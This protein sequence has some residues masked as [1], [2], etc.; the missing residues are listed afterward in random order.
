M[1]CEKRGRFGTLN[2]SCVRPV[3]SPVSVALRPKRYCDT[4]EAAK[5][6][7]APAGAVATREVHGVPARRQRRVVD[8]KREDLLG[9]G[10]QL[11]FRIAPH[12]VEAPLRV[13]L[14]RVVRD[15]EADRVV[16]PLVV[17]DEHEATGHE[18]QL[19]A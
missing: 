16:E 7:A 8:P 6:G 19:R 17:V 15:V 12:Q 13:G 9:M 5:L 1:P 4:V 18:R 14:E 11:A 2:C 3:G 10:R